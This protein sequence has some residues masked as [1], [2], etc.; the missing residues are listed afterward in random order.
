VAEAL[1]LV[2]ITNAM[3]GPWPVLRVSCEGLV[4]RTPAAKPRHLIPERNLRPAFIHE[5]RLNFVQKIETIT[6]P[7][8]QPIIGLQKPEAR[9]Q[10]P[11]D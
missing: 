7:H 3:G 5:H 1:E 4:P 9:S 6:F 2:G 10:E 8:T 11:E